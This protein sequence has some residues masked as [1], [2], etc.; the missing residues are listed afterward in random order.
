[1]KLQRSLLRAYSA[2]LRLYPSNFK[3]RFA[4]EMLDV[5]QEAEPT[6]LPF[7]FC[8]TAASVLQSW[9]K[10]A[11]TG[12]TAPAEPNGNL[13]LGES[14][15]T[16]ARLA[17]GV[18]LS[19]AILLAACYVSRLRFWQVPAGEDCRAIPSQNAQP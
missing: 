14:R 9:L 8:D 1:M 18:A 19:V 15:L 6:D 4:T 10:V 7:F 12:A 16:A 11:T 5:A 13:A 17:Q 3:R 2:L